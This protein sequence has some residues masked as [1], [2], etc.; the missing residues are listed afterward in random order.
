MGKILGSALIAGQGGKGNRSAGRRSIAIVGGPKEE[1][2]FKGTNTVEKE[3][4]QAL[5]S[6][7]RREKKKKKL[8]VYRRSLKKI[9]QKEPSPWTK[10]AQRA[11]RLWEVDDEKVPVST[12][13]FLPYKLR[14]SRNCP[15]LEKGF[16]ESRHAGA[17]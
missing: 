7:S 12:K 11:G 5:E 9:L 17:P 8:Y 14:K 6:L 2:H 10:F 16:D 1:N 3:V 4:D 15:W 13:Q